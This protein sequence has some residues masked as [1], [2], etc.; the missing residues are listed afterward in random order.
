MAELYLNFAEAASEAGW[1]IKTASN[2]SRY[3]PL[4][5]LNKIRNRAGIADLPEEYQSVEKFKERLQNERRVELCFEDHRFYDIRRLLIGT[6]IDQAI[7]RVSITKL[8]NISAEYPTGFKYERIETPYRTHVYED[9][10]NLFPINQDD[11]YMGTRF[12]QNPGW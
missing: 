8:K 5:A 4:E 10:N 2:G 12:K 3:S 6:S 1:D 7:Y 9:R 11:T